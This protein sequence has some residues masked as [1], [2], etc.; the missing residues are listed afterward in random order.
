MTNLNL[1][2]VGG[3]TAQVQLP[4]NGSTDYNDGDGNDNLVLVREAKRLTSSGSSSIPNRSGTSAA[5]APSPRSDEPTSQ[6]QDHSLMPMAMEEGDEYDDNN[7]GNDNMMLFHCRTMIVSVTLMTTR[8][9]IMVTA[10][11]PVATSF[12]HSA[13]NS[14]S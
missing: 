8:T 4:N 9:R 11:V 6:A 14:L 12:S 3:A 10:P 1:K 7:V 2:I 13:D 5:A